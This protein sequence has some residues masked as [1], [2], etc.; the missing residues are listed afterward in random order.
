MQHEV[1]AVGWVVRQCVCDPVEHAC[2][3]AGIG[4]VGVEENRLA[5]QSLNVGYDLF[6]ARKRR[7]WIEVYT[8]DVHPGTSQCPRRS[9]TEPTR[10]S[11]DECPPAF[12]FVF[13]H[14]V[15]FLG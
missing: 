5:P 1:N 10:R 8:E 2:S 3:L 14:V 6:G 7:P 12:Q 9:G 15:S 13:A 4:G 11:Q